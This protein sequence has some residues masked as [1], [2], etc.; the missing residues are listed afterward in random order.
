[1]KSTENSI[2]RGGCSV[3]QKGEEKYTTFCA[4][5]FRGTVYYH[6]DYRHKDGELFSTI[7]RTLEECREKRDKW[8]QKKNYGRLFPS[9]LKKIEGNKRLTKCDMGYQIGHVSSYHPA[10]IYWDTYKRDE[11]VAVFNKLFGTEIKKT[12]WR[13]QFRPL[14][15]P[16]VS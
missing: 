2:N 3:C 13:T 5:T 12:C 8:L 1:M 11:M 15:F 9:N 16:V 10:S 6:Y 7:G 4:G 14:F